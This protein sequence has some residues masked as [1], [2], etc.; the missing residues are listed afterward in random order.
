MT[1]V[2]SFEIC[3]LNGR[4]V[5]LSYNLDRYVNVFFGPNGSGKTSILKIIHS[6]LANEPTLLSNIAVHSANIRFHSVTYDKVFTL[7]YAKS[8]EDESAKTTKP[9]D[10]VD[11]SAPVFGRGDRVDPWKITP[12]PERGERIPRRWTHTYLPTSRLYTDNRSAIA[13]RSDWVQFGTPS[14]M[15]TGGGVGADIV[16]AEDALD[17]NFASSLQSLWSTRYGDI[18]KRV[19]AIQ[20][21]ALQSIFLDVL[22]AEA[23]APWQHL[24]ADDVAPVLAD[25]AFQRMSSFLRRQSDR[26]VQEALGS[27]QQFADR[28]NNDAKL[29][30]M[31]SRIDAV[32]AQIEQEMRPIQQLSDLVRRLFRKGKSLSFED[33]E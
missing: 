11:R 13:I 20:Q 32:E 30:Q 1:D 22:R 8:E 12:K 29:R 15:I 6:A 2:T 25:T 24:L 23:E 4:E 14:G 19:G 21:E 16:A 33:L 18:L 3:G 28:Y 5:P 7:H 27:E 10:D 9:T 31:V 17:K 26:R